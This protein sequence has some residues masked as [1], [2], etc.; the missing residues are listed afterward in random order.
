LN[1]PQVAESLK[2]EQ[3]MST[4]IYCPKDGWYV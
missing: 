3:L 2:S 1:Y 4:H